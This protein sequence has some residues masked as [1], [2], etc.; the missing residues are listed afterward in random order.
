MKQIGYVHRY[1]LKEKKGI[2][3]Y[4]YNDGPTWDSPSPILFSK[5]QCVKNIKTG[6]LVFFDI[7]ENDVVSNIQQASIFNFDKEFMQELVSVFDSKNWNDSIKRTQI[8]YQN[9]YELEEFHEYE[10]KSSKAEGIGPEENDTRPLGALEELDE[11]LIDID[12]TI[13]ELGWEFDDVFEDED[14]I[15]NGEYHKISIPTLIEEEYAL[16]GKQFRTKQTQYWQTDSKENQ[17]LYVNLLDPSLWIPPVP[18]SR[19]NYYGKNSEEC[20]NLFHILVSKERRSHDDYLSNIRSRRCD[21]IWKLDLSI[22]RSLYPD[23]FIDDCVH[24][25]WTY[26]LTRLSDDELKEVYHDCPLLQPV[27]PIDFCKRNIAMLSESYGFPSVE[28][29]NLF[30]THKIRNIKTATE[31]CHFRE[32]IYVYRNCNA[33]HLPGEGVPFCALSK[34]RLS[35]LSRNVERGFPRV[36]GNVR[37]QVIQA[38]SNSNIDLDCIIDWGNRELILSIGRFFD[39]LNKFT[40]SDYPDIFNTENIISDYKK[41]P[42]QVSSL[43]DAFISKTLKNKL[44]QTIEELEISPYSFQNLIETFSQWISSGFVSE[45]SDL[46]VAKYSGD[47]S[48]EELKAA[49]SFKYISDR[50]FIDKY[51]ELTQNYTSVE[52]LKELCDHWGFTFPDE[53]QL[54]ILRLKRE[55][56]DLNR[57]VQPYINPGYIGYEFSEIKTI[58]DFLQWLKEKSKYTNPDVSSNVYRIIQDDIISIISPDDCWYLFEKELLYTPGEKKVKEIL[59]DAY[60]QYNFKASCLTRDCFQSQIAKDVLSF[61]NT[62]LIMQAINI[63]NNRYKDSI[64]GSIKGFGEIYLWALSPDDNVN[65]L[66]L[67]TFFGE[68]PDDIQKRV[69]RFMFKLYDENRINLDILNF[70]TEILEAQAR[71]NVEETEG[72]EFF[73]ICNRKGNISSAIYALIT[74]LKTKLSSPKHSIKYTMLKPAF[75]MFAGGPFAMFRALKDFFKECVG[76]TLLSYRSQDTEYF[77]RNGYVELVSVPECD[78]Y[79]YKVCFYET[80]IDFNGYEIDYLDETNINIAEDVLKRNFNYLRYEDGCADA[81]YIIHEKDVIRLKEYITR[82]N[83]DDKCNLFNDEL[84]FGENQGYGLPEHTNYPIR[85]QENDVYICNCS[86]YKNTDSS[87]GIPFRWCMKNPC[88]RCFTFLNPASE[89]EK[90]KFADF[91]WILAKREISDSQ[92][93]QINF[94]VSHFLNTIFKLIHEKKQIDEVESVLPEEQEEVGAWTSEMDIFTDESCDDFYDYQEDESDYDCNDNEDGDSNTFERYNGSWAQDVEGYSD[95]DIDTIFDGDP[96]AY[97]NID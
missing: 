23:L 5:E 87:Y 94:E 66:G 64:A 75:T 1:S 95:D 91:L 69:F 50:V 6:C 92:L 40:E 52:H 55:E 47:I 7:N 46:L 24:E 56:L 60:S 18:K 9:I 51:I 88:T 33:K 49:Y 93:W 28:I 78:G 39:E 35:S 62:Q 71:Q 29:A 76:W 58:C 43:F 38:H 84:G 72:N 37:V 21:K 34:E 13:E 41:L 36:R 86:I 67:K 53:L 57:V 65:L 3:V 19:K 68:F 54:Y 15:P 20:I 42:N 22:Q 63:L 32:R 97:W 48:V 59:S 27:L 85:Y 16:F 77:S 73:W 8:R 2:L 26:L 82:Y 4:G 79:N 11:E 83:I 30:L 89:W 12:T 81:G 31:Y 61:S 44:I 17:Y 96:D 45:I 74:I 70:F 10:P 14:Y 90:Y 80:P 25:N